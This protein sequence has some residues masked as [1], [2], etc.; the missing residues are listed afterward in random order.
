MS[1][2]LNDSSSILMIRHG[3]LPEPKRC[4]LSLS[5]S[6]TALPKWCESVMKSKAVGGRG[7][8][9]NIQKRRE[10]WCEIKAAMN[11]RNP[12]CIKAAR[13]RAALRNISKRR[14]TRRT[15]IGM[16]RIEVCFFRYHVNT[17]EK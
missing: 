1:H 6:R 8:I 16:G 14:E 7:A 13:G 10:T 12:K 5:L 9:G 4:L 11:C 3:A 17:R 2:M 15:P